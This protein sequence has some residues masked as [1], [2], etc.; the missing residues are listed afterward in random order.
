MGTAA[1]SDFGN[2]CAFNNKTADK[3]FKMKLSLLT[4]AS[5]GHGATAPAENIEYEITSEGKLE[6]SNQIGSGLTLYK[7]WQL[8]VDLKLRKNRNMNWS[9]VF[10]LQQYD[11]DADDKLAHGD[12]GDRI[13]AVFMH[14]GA[15]T[16]HI[17]NSVNGN[18]NHCYNT[19]SV[20]TGWNNLVIRQYEETGVFNY[21]ILLNGNSE[22]K[23]QNTSPAVWQNVRAEAANGWSKGASK[24][25]FKNFQVST[26]K[27]AKELPAV[28]TRIE[29]LQELFD[30]ILANSNLREVQINKFSR[31][32]EKK[33]DDLVL[34]YEILRDREEHACKFPNTW[35][36]EEDDDDVDRYAQDNPCKA[37]KQMVTGAHKWALIFGKDCKR[38]VKNPGTEYNMMKRMM[39]KVQQVGQKVQNKMGCTADLVQITV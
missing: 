3:K 9:N 35:K 22:Y 26:T 7:E 11:S 33:T 8:S 37:V 28:E 23:I 2:R 21:E 32:F 27:P 16:L 25:V 29:K 38:E 4:L 19:G 14:A 34:L 1:Q 15:Q 18:W 24:G 12:L 17:C 6:S 20:G 13:P 10:A 30:E 31:K 36:T 5:V 39:K